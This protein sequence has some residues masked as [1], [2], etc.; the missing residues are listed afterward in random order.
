MKRTSAL[1]LL[2]VAALSL[3]ACGSENS[4]DAADSGSSANA[5]AQQDSAAKDA[6]SEKNDSKKSGPNPTVPGASDQAA[7][8]SPDDGSS[9]EP[10]G[11]SRATPSKLG[12]S[13]GTTAEGAK[14]RAHEAT[15]CEF[16]RAIYQTALKAKFEP[17]ALSPDATAIPRASI[18]V[19]SPINNESYD[20][21]CTIG[22]ANTDMDCIDQSD[23]SVG[24]SVG[25]PNAGYL[26]RAMPQ[27]LALYNG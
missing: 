15:S 13:C 18:S 10:R 27:V 9:S 4:N 3:S 21:T 23:R 20:L 17:F 1:A 26:H 19:T 5:S 2:S 12:G 6:G 22:S 8:P 14:L 25:F 16:A 7:D 24:V 11:G